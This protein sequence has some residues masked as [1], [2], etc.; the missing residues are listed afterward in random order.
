ML[1]KQIKPYQKNKSDVEYQRK[2]K[3]SDFWNSRIINLLR[4]QNAQQNNHLSDCSMD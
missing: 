2:L 1:K 3:K 4:L